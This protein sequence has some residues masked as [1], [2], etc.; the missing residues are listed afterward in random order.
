MPLKRFLFAVEARRRSVIFARRLSIR[1][2]TKITANTFFIFLVHLFV[3]QEGKYCKKNLRLGPLKFQVARGP[4]SFEEDPKNLD[5]C[6]ISRGLS[7]WLQICKKV[8][9]FVPPREI[10]GYYASIH[11]MK[12]LLKY[13]PSATHLIKNLDTFY[14][15]SGEFCRTRQ[16]SSD[17]WGPFDFGHLATLLK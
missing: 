14:D 2:T 9:D 1:T 11:N 15:F 10:L 7:H 4:R 6:D 16:T 17:S 3:S 8:E 12:I 13:A 5:V